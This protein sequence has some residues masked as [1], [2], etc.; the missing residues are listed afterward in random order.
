MGVMDN[1]VIFLYTKTDKYTWNPIF[2]PLPQETADAWYNNV[3]PE[4]GR[5]FNRDNLTAAGVRAGPSGRPWRGIDPSA[6]G[7]HWAIP[8]YLGME[9]MDTQEAPEALD[10]AG[11][12]FWPKR[13]GGV[14]MLK[15]YL[16]ES[17]GV[18]AQDVI[19]DIA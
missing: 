13:A 3:E 10:R 19:T 15:W 12:L 7:R 2:Q 18:P 14:P 16:D 17:K 6:K 8:R 5:R 4:T 11:R 9:G 1:Q